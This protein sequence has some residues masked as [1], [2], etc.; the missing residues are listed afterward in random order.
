VF[1]GGRRWLKPNTYEP[2]ELITAPT[3][4]PAARYKGIMIIRIKLKYSVRRT[5]ITN[6]KPPDARNSKFTL[7]KWIKALICRVY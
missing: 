4:M 7:R 6:H 1:I 2:T 5:F 3:T